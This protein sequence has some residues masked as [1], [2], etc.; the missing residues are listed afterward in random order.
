MAHTFRKNKQ[1]LF[2]QVMS[3]FLIVGSVGAI[4]VQL[5]YPSHAAT[6]T[7]T[8]SL[9][10][11]T[12]TVTA[13]SSVTVTINENSGTTAITSVEADLSFST[14]A[15]QYN[16]VNGSG[17]AFNDVV[18]PV[19][20][21]SGS[22]QIFR[23]SATGLTGT[24]QVATVN[25]TALKTGTIAFAG[26]SAVYAASDGSSIYSGGS[27]ATFTVPV[28]TPSP[29]PAPT[30]S[31]TPTP[32]PSVTPTP[33]PKPTTSPT[34]SPALGKASLSAAPTSGTY[35]VGDNIA[36]TISE[37][38]GTTAVSSAGPVINYTAGLLSYKG[39]DNTGSQFADIAPP[40]TTGTGTLSFTRGSFTSRTG[41]QKVATINFTV[42][43]TGTATISFGAGSTVYA[44]SG[45]TNIYGGTST[46]ASFTLQAT[47]NTTGSTGS[48]GGSNDSV[49][50]A[51]NPTL[52]YK[53]ATG[54]TSAAMSVASG[55]A[56]TASNNFVVTPVVN[57]KV[58]SDG[59]VASV[60][61][62]D[63]ILDGKLLASVTKAPYSYT[64]DSRHLR[65]GTYTLVVKTT[66]SDGTTKSS[67]QKIIIK[68]PY[69]WT[70]LSLDAKHYAWI[71]VPSGV[72]LLAGLGIAVAFLLRRRKWAFGMAGAGNGLGGYEDP[73]LHA[74]VSDT[75]PGVSDAKAPKPGRVAPTIIKPSTADSE[76]SAD[77][78]SHFSSTITLGKRPEP[79]QEAPKAPAPSNVVSPTVAPTTPPASTPKSITITTPDEPAAPANP[80]AKAETPAPKPVSP[81]N[82]PPTQ[83]P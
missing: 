45:A 35:T 38:S 72:L 25:F 83:T 4:G 78:N 27:S 32:K 71:S 31:P 2:I 73:D 58:A 44:L 23:A 36:V 61:K 54:S 55:S 42:L 7:A 34:P 81:D 66:Y 29:T 64:V 13:G 39:I 46:G 60:V 33:T 18:P 48:S 50:T 70:Q 65:N 40:V 82:K 69:S 12:G 77:D 68:N 76:A 9:S 67:S 28:A 51:S 43:K 24:H 8:L 79:V 52:T 6:G 11:A 59:S 49:S 17:S 1:Q 80:A 14:T 57:D 20:T 16:S 3:L 75:V 62:V 15:L 21:G 47:D 22:V 10:P 41:S 74:V 19:G 5:L 53:A 56:L 37:N 26:S 30:P 63:Y